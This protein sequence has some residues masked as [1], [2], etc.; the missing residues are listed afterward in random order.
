M[1]W[2]LGFVVAI[3]AG[4]GLLLVLPAPID[5]VSWTPD[6]N[7]GLTGPFEPN[8]QLAEAELSARRGG[9]GPGGCGLRSGRC[10]LHR[11]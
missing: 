1:R 7:P 10:A 2:L 9:R 4:T 6:P 3:I 8:R 11:V 5:P